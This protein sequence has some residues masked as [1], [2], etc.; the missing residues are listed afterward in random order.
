MNPILIRDSTELVITPKPRARDSASIEIQARLIPLSET[1]EHSCSAYRA[2][3][4][5][6][7]FPS[8]PELTRHETPLLLATLLVGQPDTT[9]KF[10]TFKRTHLLLVLDRNIAEHH[11]AVSSRL[12][13]DHGLEIGRLYS[14]A[15]VTLSSQK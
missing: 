2:Y 9:A 5:P 3:L 1:E 7:S 12:F 6:L 13:I 11:I 10:P 14:Y 8:E 4:N 15:I